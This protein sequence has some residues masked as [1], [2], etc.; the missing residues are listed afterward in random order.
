MSI[1]ENQ[2]FKHSLVNYLGVGLS[3]VSTVFIYNLNLELYGF[4]Q[5]LTSTAAFMIPFMTLGV[6]GLILR[7]YP[8]FEDPTY[9]TNF[10]K[11][12][13]ILFALSSSA[14]LVLYFLFAD[15]FIEL[16]Q[17]IRVDRKGILEEYFGYVIILAILTGINRM[18]TIHA[19]NLKRI[20]I[21]EI[22]N[23]LSY[24][25]L[26]PVI[27]LLGFYGVIGK[28]EALWIIIL[29]FISIGLLLAFYV[30]KIGGFLGR[31]IKWH[32]VD[33][34]K[35]REIKSFTFYSAL[36][37]LSASFA[38]RIDMVMLSAMLGFTSN[39]VYA[40]LL[41]LTNI[42][43]IPRKSLAKIVSPY[44]AKSSK[45][46]DLAT[47]SKLYKKASITLLVPSILV[48][49][50][51]W[52]CL[53]ELDKIVSGNPVFWKNRYLF[54]LIALGRLVDMLLSMNS[55]II[56]YSRHYRY[57]FYFIIVLA[58]ANIIMNYYLINE[59]QILGA[60]ISTFIA[61][62]LYNLL[63]SGLI[64]QAL[65]IHPF[66]RNVLPL[67]L[68]SVFNF[69]ILGL[70]PIDMNLLLS[71]PLKILILALLY[72]LPS[73]YLRLSPDINNL[74]DKYTSKLWPF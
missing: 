27:V 69:F 16:M 63:K 21:P 6:M 9:R 31:P 51:I 50:L 65:K 18:L 62:L 70:I 14:F 56:S 29:F 2:G 60:A 66:H 35:R 23:N 45:E 58:I 64:W 53:P 12:I 36:N 68:I 1:I 72:A 52:S 46:G 26:L 38:F 19:S 3:F 32:S 10:I 25:L 13:F 30:H 8:E 20:V 40:I 33:R 67:I 59:Y 55:E 74:F 39:G 48:F 5:F 71:I 61:F 11:S 57:N 37:G 24:K 15:D 49:L 7:Y 17:F 43:D 47:T 22:I 4:A 34:P 28:V 54:L 73:Y 42:I 44:L 41:F